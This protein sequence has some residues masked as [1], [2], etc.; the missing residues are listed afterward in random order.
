[1]SEQ[2]IMVC[3]PQDHKLPSPPGSMPVKCSDCPTIVT[4]SPSTWPILRS[5]PGVKVVCPSCA[6]TYK[7]TAFH[8][9]TPA[10]IDEL[11]EVLQGGNG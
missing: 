1:M 11:I 10:Q 7:I 8:L 9:P 5:N 4:V 3:L 6:L 2:G